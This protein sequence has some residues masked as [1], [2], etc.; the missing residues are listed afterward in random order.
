MDTQE[1]FADLEKKVRIVYDVAE[2]ARKKGLDPKNKVEVPLAK[3][4][5]EKVVA[6]I[7]TVYPQL[8]NCGADKRILELEKEYG[9]LDTAVAFKIAEEVAKQKFCKF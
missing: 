1:Y 5:A 7:S 4:M 2:A 3:S 9:K 8:L 6:L